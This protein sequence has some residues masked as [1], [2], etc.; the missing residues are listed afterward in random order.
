MKLGM[1]GLGKM[2]ANMTRRLLRNDHDV[3][4]FDLSEDAVQEIQ[5]AGAGGATSLDALVDHLDPPRVLWMM[6]PAGDPVDQTIDTL[7]PLVD[8]GDILIDGGNSNYKDTLRRADR[9]QEHGVHYVDVGTSGGVWGLEQGYSM[10][11]GGPDEAVDVLRPALETLAPGPDKGW[12]HM[13]TVG[14]GHFVKMVHNGIEY[15]MMQAFAEGFDI[16]QA[17]PEFDLDLHQVAETWR[18][19]SVIRSWLLDLT[20]RALEDDPDLPDIAPWVNDSGEG[21]WTVKEAIDLDVPAPVITD[22]LIARLDS[23]VE[24]SYTHKLLAAMR[25]QFGG[26]AVKSSDE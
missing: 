8:D 17:K 23:R 4:G 5:A 15:G 16:M 18:F 7:L 22:A 6:V 13:G 9:V 12:G 25:N 20:A 14:S 1:I 19:G 24:D 10:M 26:H 2:G 11:V 21:R 3:V